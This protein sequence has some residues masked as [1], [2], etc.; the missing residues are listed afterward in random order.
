MRPEFLAKE[1]LTAKVEELTRRLK[2]LDVRG[3][4]YAL[5]PWDTQVS[6]IAQSVMA[7][8]GEDAVIRKPGMRCRIWWSG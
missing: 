8:S 3:E 1:G 5:E 7:G 6:A 4:P 2:A